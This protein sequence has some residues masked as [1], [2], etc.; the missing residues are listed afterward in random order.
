MYSI[1]IEHGAIIAAGLSLSI[2]LKTAPTLPDGIYYAIGLDNTI[3]DFSVI[4]EEVFWGNTR[5]K[6]PGE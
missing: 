2:L 4:D 1:R 5:K 6:Y 3:T